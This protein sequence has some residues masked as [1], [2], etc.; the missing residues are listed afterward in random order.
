MRRL[1]CRLSKLN[2]TFKIRWRK[3][4]KKKKKYTH[5]H[6]NLHRFKTAIQPNTLPSLITT[7]FSSSSLSAVFFCFNL[8]IVS[9]HSWKKSVEQFLK[10]VYFWGKALILGEFFFLLPISHLVSL[11]FYNNK[12]KRS[13][14]STGETFL[15]PINRLEN[16]SF[17]FFYFTGDNQ[18]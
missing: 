12:R 5:T 4:P 13:S 11:V 8:S 15:A 1:L 9:T 17:F 18:K 14:F 16:I 7:S 3:Q 6:I 2:V 10:Q